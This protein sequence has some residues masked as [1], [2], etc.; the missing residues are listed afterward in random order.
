M[1]DPYDW[2]IHDHAEFEVQLHDFA[3]VLEAAQ[4]SQAQAL[5]ERLVVLVLSHIAMEEQVLYPAYEGVRDLPRRPVAALRA[6][7]ERLVA[8]L[9]A[10]A[11]ELRVGDIH[12]ALE[13]LGSLELALINHHEREEQFFLP[14]AGRLLF[15]S[16][17][18]IEARIKAF[19]ATASGRQ[20]SL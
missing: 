5:F 15:D 10:L 19:E 16:R 6:E 18:A 17:G 12:S 7:H 2:L 11:Q 8:L 4:W 3:R 14:M 20:W 9:R 13:A 1:T